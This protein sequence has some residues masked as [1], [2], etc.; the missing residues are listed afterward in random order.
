MLLRVLQPKQSHEGVIGAAQLKHELRNAKL[1]DPQP[2][3]IQL[4]GATSVLHLMH[5]MVVPSLT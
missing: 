2:S 3:H 4:P 5:D 1:I